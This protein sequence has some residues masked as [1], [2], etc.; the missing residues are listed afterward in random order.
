MKFI[1]SPTG[2][3]F[4]RS[5]AFIKG[6]MGPVGGG[7]STVC[8]MDLVSRAYGQAAFNGVRR[9][10]FAIV[11]NTVQQLMS[12]VKPLVD[13]WLITMPTQLYGAPIAEWTAT[14][15]TY[16]IR[17]TG[18]PDENG[19]PT[20]VF[21]EI[22]LMNADTP[23]DV[24]RLLSLQ[25]SAAW[26]EEAREIDPEVF[27]GLLGRVDRFP[28]VVAGGVTYPGVVFSTNAPMMDTYWQEM[29]EDPPENAEVFIQPEA[30]LEDGSIN[31]DAE[32]LAYLSED[33]YPNLMAA[34][35]AEWVA[36]YL[37][38][39]YGPGNAGL[40][41]YRASFRR[42]FHAA[43]TELL[44][45][46][47]QASPLVVGCDNGL[48]AAAVIMQ[49]DA[50]SRVNV[51]ST[52]HVPADTTMGFERFL[53]TILIPHLVAAYPKAPRTSFLFVM[54]PA[55]FQRSQLNEA[56]LAQ[57]VQAR[58]YAAVRASTNDPQKRV[59]AVEGLLARAVDTKAGLLIDP[60]CTHLLKALE[61][62]YRYKKAS[63]GSTTTTFEKNHFSH[64]AEAMQYGCLHY[65]AQFSQ[66]FTAFRSVAR[67]VQK[68]T[69]AYV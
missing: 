4:I 27:K 59:E 58:G 39:K 31:P 44:A 8:L 14:T 22:V 67:K 45:I 13:E 54:D 35:T 52:A 28:S 17:A 40:P 6:I 49:Q 11:R 29:L 38:N 19:A 47:S 66:T 36:V 1:P 64:I 9:T 15:K 16:T 26:A 55:C 60:R 37:R 30:V 69:Y 3:R 24:R 33:Y 41:V 43:E 53:D 51:L 25:L 56:T 12:T 61:W 10:K 23:D 68:R 65:N 20:Q 7:K 21:C 2:K 32:N 46:P 63:D 18:A 42:G 34:N 57:A 5:T 48:Q 62:G 50:R